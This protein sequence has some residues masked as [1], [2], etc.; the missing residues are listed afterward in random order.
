MLNVVPHGKGNHISN[1]Y[2]FTVN[3]TNKSLFGTIT[4]MGI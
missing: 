4:S 3:L 1:Q 2:N